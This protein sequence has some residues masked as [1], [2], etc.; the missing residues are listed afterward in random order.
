[1]LEEILYS[2][3]Y[4]NTIACDFMSLV[5]NIGYVALTNIQGKST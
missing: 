2:K 5:H 3:T 4:R 1:M